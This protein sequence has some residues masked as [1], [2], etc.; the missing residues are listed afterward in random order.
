MERKYLLLLLSFSFLS[1]FASAQEYQVKTYIDSTQILIGDHL[2]VKL[3][4]KTPSG[5]KVVIPQF[6]QDVF[7]ESGIEWIESSR[8]DTVNDGANMIDRKSVV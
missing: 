3:S 4:V 6:N 5:V 1:I 8:I 7:G 2:N